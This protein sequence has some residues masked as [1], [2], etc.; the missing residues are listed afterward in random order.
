MGLPIDR[1]EFEESE[2]VRF[3]ERLDE[4][5]AA[6]RALLERPGFGVGEST[7]GA[8]LELFL[9]DAEGR[10]LPENQAI[11]AD[12]GHERVTTEIGRFNLELNPKP[13]SLAGR[14][15]ATLGEDMRDVL[16]VVRRSTAKHGGRVAMIGILPTLRSEDLQR[17][18]ITDTPRYQAINKRLLYLRQEPVRVTIQ[19]VDP[20][21][22][23]LERDH[24][25]FE[26]ANTSFQVHLRVDPERFADAYNAA[27]MITA[28][29]LA[30]AANSPIFLGRRLWDETRV[31]LFEQVADDRDELGRGRRVP[32]VAFGTRWAREGVYELFEQSVPAPDPLVP[33]LDAEADPLAV[34]RARRV[35]RLHELP[36][37]HATVWRW[38]G[39]I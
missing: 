18:A 22:L 2:Y 38:H 4:C 29:A 19:G 20:E 9:I 31:A 16:G 39:P 14:P 15:F 24:V 13:E 25:A 26:G 33:V 36:L 7:V 1:D 23:E 21:P 8:E 3:G 12:A 28:P 37:H 32:R 17:S 27:Q 10:P 11:L 5:L 34:V 30:L 35:A 6:L